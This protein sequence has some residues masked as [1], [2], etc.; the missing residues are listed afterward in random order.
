MML[1]LKEILT[2][3]A[4][5]AAIE[6]SPAYLGPLREAGRM[7]LHDSENMTG[8]STEGRTGQNSS[9]RP[10]CQPPTITTTPRP[11]CRGVFFPSIHN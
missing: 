7:E 2:R 6:W 5:S 1:W 3:R 9:G 8:L 10:T 4:L 11:M